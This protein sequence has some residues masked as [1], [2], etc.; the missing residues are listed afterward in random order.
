MQKETYTIPE[1]IA[2]G[3]A[4]RTTTYREA[5]EGRLKIQK[6]GAKSFITSEERQRWL[7]S[8]PTLGGSNEA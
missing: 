7:A 6:I 1:F 5:R 2:A 8:L 3:P 4:G